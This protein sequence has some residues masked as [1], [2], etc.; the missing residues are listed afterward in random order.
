MKVVGLAQYIKGVQ[1][2]VTEA[3]IPNKQLPKFPVFGSKNENFHHKT[4]CAHMQPR[5]A[6]FDRTSWV[7]GNHEGTFWYKPQQ[8]YEKRKANHLYFWSVFIL[9]SAPTQEKQTGQF[10]KANN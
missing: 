1:H 3:T 6:Q 4:S 7:R 9:Q 8:I 10:Q 2:F 5:L